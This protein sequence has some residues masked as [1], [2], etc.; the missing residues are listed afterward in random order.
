M[1]YMPRPDS[2]RFEH[3]GGSR[4]NTKAEY[5]VLACKTL[6]TDVVSL[7]VHCFREAGSI[8]TA[9]VACTR[10]SYVRP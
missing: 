7:C 4:N 3:S 5:V 10:Y 2:A 1:A 9:C 8:C 6:P